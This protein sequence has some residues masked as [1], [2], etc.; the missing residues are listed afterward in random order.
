MA[1]GLQ[2]LVNEWLRLDQNEITRKEISD[3][4]AARDEH[5]LESRLR[6]RIEFGTAGTTFAHQS[7]HCFL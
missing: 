7:R 1:E 4:W 3:L 6:K 2:D 5:E